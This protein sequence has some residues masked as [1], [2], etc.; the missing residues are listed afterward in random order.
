M[1]TENE[2]LNSSNSTLYKNGKYQAIIPRDENGNPAVNSDT[3]LIAY[4]HAAYNGQQFNNHMEKLDASYADNS[5]LAFVSPTSQADSQYF[6]STAAAL[7]IK[8]QNTIYAGASL[9]GNYV[10]PQLADSISANPEVKNRKCIFFE[11]VISKHHPYK[12]TDEQVKNIKE[13]GATMFLV[14]SG[15]ASYGD[16]TKNIK[17]NLFNTEDSN[18]RIFHVSMNIAGNSGS[19]HSICCNAGIS[20]EYGI[21]DLLAGDPSKFYENNILNGDNLKYGNTSFSPTYELL[22]KGKTIK[23]NS[24]EEFYNYYMAVENLDKVSSFSKK[25]EYLETMYNVEHAAGITNDVISNVP[26]LV[27]DS[28]N[29]FK[30]CID[31]IENISPTS[32]LSDSIGLDEIINETITAYNRCIDSFKTGMTQYA[33]LGIKM[34]N[35]YV[36]L[37]SNLNNLAN[38]TK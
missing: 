18:V 12:L 22:Y 16:F 23:F 32:G 28:M 17:A 20:S 24:T 21:M 5:N 13:N 1:N 37:D 36:N 25:L 19:K 8:P 10:L 4:S 2:L 6:D 14:D 3:T 34:S 29:E 33:N 7:N 35:M 9:G 38:G 15:E 27:N 11:P 31:K 26:S 30:K